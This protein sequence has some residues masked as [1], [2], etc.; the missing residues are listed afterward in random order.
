MTRGQ[1]PQ[2]LVGIVVVHEYVFKSFFFQNPKMWLTI[3]LDTDMAKHRSHN[4]N[5]R[6]MTLLTFQYMEQI[7]T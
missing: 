3:F 6:I 5:I 4:S 1:L 7:I 2:G